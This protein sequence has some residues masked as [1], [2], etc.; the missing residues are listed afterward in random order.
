VSATRPFR[1]GVLGGG[2]TPELLADCALR[3]EQLGYAVF[4]S[5]DH[6]DLN[7]SHLSELSSIT[8]LAYAAAVTTTIRL[9]ASVFNQD[10]RHPA[11]LA[12]DIAS[13][14]VLSGGRFE[15]GIGAGHSEYE[16]DW[17]GIPFDEAKVRVERVEE[18]VQVVKRILEL[19]SASYDGKHF[20]IA[21][22]PG[23]P[24]PAQRPRPPVMVGGAGKRM[25]SIAARE[26]DIVGINLN[27]M[28]AGTAERM[29]E[30]SR[31][32]RD[33]AG[34]RWEDIEIANMVGTLVVKDGERRDAL[35]AELRRQKAAGLEFI[36][37]GMSER[38]ILDSP[39]TLVGSVG[40]LVDDIQR[41]R[42][43]WGVSYITIAYP[44]MEQF[45]PVLEQLAGQ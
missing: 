44:L 32:V 11:V 5:T 26:A 45:A 39:T 43:R 31:W 8:A 38:E 34:S 42:E 17:A 30:R 22:M 40:Q 29:D 13:L 7:G 14:D 28:T 25:L 23:I 6:L 18:Y 12:R 21:E 37:A 35:A 4:L 1:F 3:A 15:V 33:A 19:D 16:Y 27:D 41:W 36:T 24:R 9:G 2:A 20:Q 10:L